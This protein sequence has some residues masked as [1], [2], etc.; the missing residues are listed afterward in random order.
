[1]DN[2]KTPKEIYSAI[3]EWAEIVDMHAGFQRI[4][5]KTC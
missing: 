5:G 3:H 2:E 1:M 4:D